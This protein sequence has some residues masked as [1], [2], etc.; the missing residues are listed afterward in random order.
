MTNCYGDQTQRKWK[1]GA[2]AQKKM[3]YLTALANTAGMSQRCTSSLYLSQVLH[4]LVHFVRVFMAAKRYH[5][6][7]S[8]VL[9]VYF[10][11]PAVRGTKWHHI[12]WASRRQECAIG[13]NKPDAYSHARLHRP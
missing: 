1:L 11:L 6:E 4:I 7:V 10:Y 2:V 13:V 8:F 3:A 5:Y 9:R 12:H